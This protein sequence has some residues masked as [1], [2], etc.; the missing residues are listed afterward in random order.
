[1]G[2]GVFGAG[3]A[4]R[5]I[6]H[7]LAAGSVVAA[8]VSGFFAE[9]LEGVGLE[10]HRLVGIFAL[11]AVLALALLRVL[12]G[13]APLSGDGPFLQRLARLNHAG[14]LVL[15]GALALTGLLA[16]GAG[17]LPQLGGE[18]LDFLELEDEEE[19]SGELF[20]E[21]HELLVAPFLALWG[22]HLLGAVRR[23]LK[24]RAGFGRMAAG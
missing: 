15:A 10:A 6:L 16:D 20:A 23:W 3:E 5:R 13:P 7:A 18:G 11:G 14:L 24:G 2:K 8:L 17:D 12:Y 19:G 1:M 4:V 22:L 21:L 9:E